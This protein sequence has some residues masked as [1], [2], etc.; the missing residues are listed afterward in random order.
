MSA[1]AALYPVEL[2]PCEND[3]VKSFSSL[4][5]QKSLVD[6]GLLEAWRAEG[7]R[8]L[9]C[10]TL[11]LRT[12][13]QFCNIRAGASYRGNCAPEQTKPRTKNY[14]RLKAHDFV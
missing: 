3:K 13:L 8:Q 4:H 7:H 1:S 2:R 12:D 14:G 10:K 6:I 5:P 9:A 11:I